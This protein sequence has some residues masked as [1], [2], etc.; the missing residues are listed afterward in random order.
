MLDVQVQLYVGLY[1]WRLYASVSNLLGS[2]VAGVG[3][4][5]TIEGLAREH[6]NQSNSVLTQHRTRANP[7]PHQHHNSLVCVH[8][9]DSLRSPHEAPRLTHLALKH[10]RT[11]ASPPRDRVF[12]SPPPVPVVLAVRLKAVTEASCRHRRPPSARRRVSGSARRSASAAPFLSGSPQRQRRFSLASRSM[13]RSTASRVSRPLLPRLGHGGGVSCELPSAVELA[14]GFAGGWEDRVDTDVPLVP[15][16]AHGFSAGE[17]GCSTSSSTITGGRVCSFVASPAESAW[18]CVAA[19]GV[20]DLP[21][22]FETRVLFD[23]RPL[24][25]LPELWRQESA[26]GGGTAGSS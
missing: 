11:R 7:P 21:P 17:A 13:A 1:V 23:T 25:A 22:K 20:R 15:G 18:G 14:A 16:V 2:L 26:G 4:G 3:R 9:V 19:D 5:A 8:T 10:A 6:L 24:D 12:A